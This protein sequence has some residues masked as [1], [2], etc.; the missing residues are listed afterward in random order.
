MDD[1]CILHL[2]FIKP[3]FAQMAT[4]QSNNA[5]DSNSIFM[6]YPKN[7]AQFTKFNAFYI[8]S[9]GRSHVDFTDLNES[10]EL[11]LNASPDFTDISSKSISVWLN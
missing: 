7:S 4:N 11:F 10:I 2:A 9:P 6:W 1:A 8:I 5:F 3:Q